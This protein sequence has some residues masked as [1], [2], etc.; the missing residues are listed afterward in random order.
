VTFYHKLNIFGVKK[1]RISQTFYQS[2]IVY[3]CHYKPR[4]Q[5]VMQDFFGG[6][7]GKI[8]VGARNQGMDW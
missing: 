6:K 4:I 2:A 3:G 1:N 5:E 7:M 8:A